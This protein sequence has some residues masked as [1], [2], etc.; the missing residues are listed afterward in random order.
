M[1]HRAISD[2]LV[3]PVP[4]VKP[5]NWGLRERMV[6]REKWDCPVQL[7]PP[8]KVAMMARRE[9]LDRRVEKVIWVT[10]EFPDFLA[11]KGFRV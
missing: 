11:F 2:Y 5:G 3:R 10:L 6:K 1:D 8:E 7:V 9:L 4:R